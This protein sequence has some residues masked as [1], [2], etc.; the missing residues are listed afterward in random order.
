MN[1]SL[2]ASLG[3]LVFAAVLL[4]TTGS[5]SNPPAGNHATDSPPAAAG[6]KSAGD[7]PW[8]ASCDYWAPARPFAESDSS[9]QTNLSFTLDHTQHSLTAILPDMPDKREPQCGADTQE[10]WGLPAGNSGIEINTL[11]AIVPDPVRTNMALQFDRTVD[12]LLAAAGEY[13]YM[14]SYYWVPWKEQS[15]RVRSTE[16]SPEKEQDSTSEH[17]PGLIIFKY[18]PR[19]PDPTQST[20]QSSTESAFTR[21]LYLFLVGETPTSGIDGLQIQKAF[22][23]QDELATSNAKVFRSF[24]NDPHHLSLIGPTF[25]GSA[26][27]VRQAVETFLKNHE[28]TSVSVNGATGTQLA[29]FHMTATSDTQHST[30]S[31]RGYRVSEKVEYRSFSYDSTY[32][33]NQL[34]KLL[35][36]SS[37]SSNPTR[38]AVL[39]ED[40]TTFGSASSH[41][42]TR[43]ASIEP[44]NIRFPRGIFLLRNAQA[45]N[46]RSEPTSPDAPAS[47]YL[48]LSLKDANS[49]DSVPQLSRENTPLSQEAQLMTI[50]RQL[51]R[52]GSEF[53]V[54]SATNVLDQLFL[55]QF[56]HRACPDA[57]LL[58]YSGDLL[59]ERE[60]DNVPFVGTL[61]FTPYPLIGTGSALARGNQSRAYPDSISQAYFNAASYTIWDPKSEKSPAIAGYRNILEP[62]DKLH[63]TLWVTAIGSDGYYP[64]G[65]AGDQASNSDTIGENLTSR[66]THLWYFL[67]IFVCILCVLHSLILCVA[68]PWSPATREL[69]FKDNDQPRRRAMYVH[70]GTVMLFCMAFVVSF[71]LFAT[72]RFRLADWAGIFTSS[73]T[74]AMGTLA[75]AVTF[76]K[77]QKYIRWEIMADPAVPPRWALRLNLILRHNVYLCLNMVAWIALLAVS[78][79]WSY[80][81][82][83]NSSG[84]SVLYSHVGLCFSYRCIHPESGV[85]PLVPVL[86]LLFSWYLWSVFHSWRLRFSDNSRPVLPGRLTLHTSYPLFV[87]DEDLRKCDRAQSP[88]LYKDITCLFITR[89]VIRRICLAL[90]PNFK[91]R[92]VG[93]NLALAFLYLLFFCLFVFLVPVKSLDDFFWASH[94]F[95]TLY[96]F[97]I[98]ALFFPLLVITLTGWLRMVFIWAALKRNLLDRL[99]NYPIRFAFTRLNAAGWMTMLRRGGLNEQWRDMARCT[100]S[101]RQM[102]NDPDLDLRVR[103]AMVSGTAPNPKWI[104]LSRSINPLRKID[105][106]MNF[107]IKALIMH[108]GGIK[109]KSRILRVARNY[110][111][112]QKDIPLADADIGLVLMNAIERCYASF[113]EVL[114]QR[115]LVPHWKA[116]SSDFVEAE[117]AETSPESSVEDPRYIRV[118]EEFLA[119]RYLSLIRAVL[120]NLRYLM[121]FVSLSFVLAIVA[122]NSYPFEPRQ[123]ID[124]VFTGLLAVL[125]GGMIL[126]LAQMHRDP[127]LNRIT[128]TKANELGAEFYIRIIA[129]GAVPVLTWLAYEF[130][131]IGST[132]FRFIKPGLE[133]I[134]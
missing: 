126:V 101:M 70:T 132:I 88:C 67:C 29:L 69:A 109:P 89:E 54:I 84:S 4:R 18:A 120:V 59:F 119:I 20:P 117:T 63:P 28:D 12:S 128:H 129:F 75:L 65:I 80:L 78:S 38:V 53:I 7:G 96:E 13:Q 81:C 21:V 23:Y 8:S 36:Q 14:S 55:A 92:Y 112:T 30:D 49:F 27:S 17:E 93:F 61:T 111:F 107:F 9:G 15:A 79:L 104:P 76:W 71:P 72:S 40:G 35:T 100:E 90:I 130:P 123:L 58:F 103:R 26:A 85:S 115:V 32:S 95:P 31:K 116:K 34:L 87:A 47:P 127:I 124:W 99:E 56:L 91:D 45:E 133:V 122:W 86:L 41:P 33:L 82:C 3:A 37:S 134:K 46:A 2:G 22:K 73:L 113:S 48:R 60:I 98:T 83:R 57:R 121:V 97:L 131:G 50:A 64:L 77:T 1:K 74:L 5:T 125:G 10:R 24:K 105:C 19:L 39:S 44:L 25:T 110:L 42:I 118:A 11:I 68:D 62:S 102:V 43:G 52:N 106:H 94:G 114:L 6:K 51:Q 66:P 108:R 16:A